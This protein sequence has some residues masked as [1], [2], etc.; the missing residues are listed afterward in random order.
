MP[1]ESAASSA[2]I[3]MSEADGVVVEAVKRSED[4]DHAI[5]RLYETHGARA[6]ASVHCALPIEHIIECDLLERPLSPESSPAF[7]LWQAS[8]AASHDTPVVDGQRWSCEFRPFEV[9][10]FRVKLA[11][12][13]QDT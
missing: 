10:T 2:I 9:R 1:G 12:T 11:G 3:F 7:A 8:P 13:A 6:Q 5:V 4:G